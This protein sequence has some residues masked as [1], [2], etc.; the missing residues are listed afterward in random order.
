M[1][2]FHGTTADNAKRILAEGFKCEAGGENWNV[3]GNNVYFWSPER[4][5]HYDDNFEDDDEAKR[6][7]ADSATF[8]LAFAKDCRFV[9][10]EVEID[11]ELQDD[12]SC[13][14]M[15]G[16]VYSY[17]DVPASAIRA[18]HISEDLSLI[19]G[20]FLAFHLDR[21]MTARSLTP[22]QTK[23]ARAFQKAEIYPDDEGMMETKEFSVEEAK[24]TLDI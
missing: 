23:I 7:A 21:D 10:F 19:K 13:E 2:L 14:N 1:K 4:I 5:S 8:G 11:G 18:V 9:I 16:A 12:D 3:S 20:Y 17:E 24:K 22:I 6:R 15:E